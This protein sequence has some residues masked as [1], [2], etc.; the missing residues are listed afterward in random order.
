MSTYFIEV[1][2]AELDC[3]SRLRGKGQLDS[4]EV[5]STY[6]TN[7]SISEDD[8]LIECYVSHHS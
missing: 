4:G 6:F 7:T 5:N 1:I 8:Q 2:Q 3:K